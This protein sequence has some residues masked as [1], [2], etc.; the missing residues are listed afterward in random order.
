[1]KLAALVLILGM[2]WQY[3][4][5]AVQRSEIV[6]D[7]EIQKAEIDAYNA[8]ILE[9][10]S[11]SAYKDGVYQGTA[12][13]FGG[14]ITVEITIK[15]KKIAQIEVLDASGEDSAYFEQAKEVLSDILLEQSGQA[16]TVSGATFSSQGLI[17]AVNEALE[18]AVK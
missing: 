16:D 15:N 13:G 11:E 4:Q 17:D 7:Y 8:Q 18:K 6:S 5:I 1:M 10:Q 3:Q 9:A 14:D 12:M 2:L